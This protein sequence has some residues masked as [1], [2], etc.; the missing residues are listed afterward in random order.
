[1]TYCYLVITPPPLAAEEAVS[2]LS[3]PS[4]HPLAAEE[5][6]TDL[7][8]PSYHPT[9]EPV[10]DLPSPDLFFNYLLAY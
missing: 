8:L 4:Y 1:M 10:C 2:D 9:K 3:L 5:A 6:V 7:L